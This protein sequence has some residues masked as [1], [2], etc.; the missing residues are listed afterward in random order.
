MHRGFT[1]LRAILTALLAVV[2]PACRPDSPASSGV[3]GESITN[4][5][6]RGVVVSLT[7]A[8]RKVVIRHE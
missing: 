5:L 3:S 2:L 7:P 6:T 8:E 4:Y 1:I